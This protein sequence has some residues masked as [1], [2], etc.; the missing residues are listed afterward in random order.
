[1]ET[2]AF[3]L[4]GLMD[5]AAVDWPAIGNG[6][7]GLRVLSA[8]VAAVPA[9]RDRY[10][11]MLMAGYRQYRRF[12]IE[13][14]GQTHADYM[15]H[16]SAKTR[17]TL[18]RK[19][20]KLESLSGGRL[21][22]REFHR[23]EDIAAFVADAVPLSRRTYQARLLNA[24][25]PEGPEAEAAMRA[26]ARRDALRAYILY[27]DGRAVSYLYLP[28]T[29]GVVTYAFLGYAD[30]AAHLSVGT[31]LQME[32]LERLFAE[33]RYR[34]FDFTEGEGAHKSMFGT[35]SVEACSFF[36][37]RPSLAN[38]VLAN[39]LAA[40]DAGIAGIKRVAETTGALARVRQMLRA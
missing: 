3:D 11:D 37:L 35:A 5:G 34:Y 8:P 23:E 24:G 22:L 33:S 19:R 29:S 32:A 13:M 36:L 15:A 21:D 12:Y 6:A 26:L 40:F 1:M 25:L 17:S 31:V 20:R 9:V 16:F 4:D 30:D 38:R 18:N 7:D 2:R 39:S 28:T 10:P 27:L 14:A